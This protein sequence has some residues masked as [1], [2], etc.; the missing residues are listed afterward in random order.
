MPKFT[1]HFVEGITPDPEKVLRFWDA[2]LK[3]FGLIVLP[4]GRR[5]YCIDYR[6]TDRIKKRLKI[7]VH[8]ILTTEEARDLAKKRLRQ[9]AHGEDPV[10]YRKQARYLATVEKLAN[11]YFEYY[12]CNKTHKNLQEDQKLL[13]NIILPDL[14]HIK[15][16]SITQDDI[17]KLHK[18][19]EKTPS[20][21]NRVLLLLFN[22]F[23]SAVSWLWRSDN[24][25]LGVEKYPE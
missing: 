1:Q 8:G 25:V 5:T 17:K 6:N 13:Q 18:K 7:G 2:E 24:P 9:V 21:A 10:E 19:L 15:V 16:S 22:M 4:S 11:N 20:Q 12:V 23:S 14:G 3:G